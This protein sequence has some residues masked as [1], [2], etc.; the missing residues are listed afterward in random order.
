MERAACVVPRHIVTSS[1]R[2]APSIE[3]GCR[4][5]WR[6]IAGWSMPDRSSTTGVRSVPAATTTAGARTT[7]RRGR[8]STVTRRLHARGHRPSSRMH[9]LDRGVRD[10]PRP[11]RHAS[12]RWTRRP[13]CLAPRR[14][15]KPH[16]PQSPQST[17]LRRVSPTSYAQHRAPRR[18]SCVLG[19]H[20]RRLADAELALERCDVRVD[21]RP[22][23]PRHAVPGRPAAPHAARAARY[24]SSS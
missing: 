10:D 8:P 11:C 1:S 15:P 4:R 23:D 17:P 16:R 7:S 24:R 9:P 14:Q 13:D 21:P 6:P 20:V 12:A 3:T 19:R 5:R 18:I 2:K 22:V